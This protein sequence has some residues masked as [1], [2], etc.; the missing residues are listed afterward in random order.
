MS[1]LPPHPCQPI[2][3]DDN[4]I[5]R[6]KQNT[7]V[8]FLL[9]NGGFVDLNKLAIMEFPREDKVQFAQLIGYSICG[10]G[11]LSYVSDED[12]ERICKEPE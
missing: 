3:K 10:F 5:S 2:I 4:G 8:R 6:F 1:K 11:E 12:F 7:I 9:N